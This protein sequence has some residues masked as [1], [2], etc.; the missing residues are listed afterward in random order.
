MGTCLSESSACSSAGMLRPA[1]LELA[2]DAA[3]VPSSVCG[4]RLMLILSRSFCT[5]EVCMPAEM[6]LRKRQARH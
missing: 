2:L 1:K 5:A 4:G 6:H 3:A